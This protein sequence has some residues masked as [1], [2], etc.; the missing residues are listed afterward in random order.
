MDLISGANPRLTRGTYG[1]AVGGISTCPGS[2][3]PCAPVPL[4]LFRD[5]AHTDLADAI[6]APA[7]PAGRRR[8]PSDGRRPPMTS[9]MLSISIDGG[10]TWSLAS[11]R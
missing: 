5:D 2:T 10:V 4:I 1:F 11:G 9:L 3:D 8:P 6:S 7:R